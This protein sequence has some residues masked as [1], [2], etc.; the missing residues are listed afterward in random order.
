MHCTVWLL[1]RVASGCA[2]EAPGARLGR[3]TTRTIALHDVWLASDPLTVVTTPELLRAYQVPRAHAAA[4]A[5]GC[6]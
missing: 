6:G 4:P 1:A 5:A 3:A 2:G